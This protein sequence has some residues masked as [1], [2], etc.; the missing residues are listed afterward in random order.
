[1]LSSEI[2]FSVG[3]FSD[4]AIAITLTVSW[5]LSHH[6]GCRLPKSQFSSVQSLSHVRL[7]ATSWTAARQTSLS[8]TNSHSLP[9]LM[10]I[11]SVMPSTHLTLCR[12]LLLLLSIFPSINVFSH[13]SAL[14]I[15]WPKYWNFSFNV[16]PSDE[17]PGLTSFRMDWFRSYLNCLVVSPSFFSL[18]LNL[19]IRSSWSEAQSASRLVFA[20]CIELLHLCLQRI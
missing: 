19:A 9:K 3:R 18:S 4:A 2:N 16:S 14:H 8:I 12:P 15:R 20:D 13:E 7:F 1:M 5:N 6:Q 17:Y 11:E 10:S